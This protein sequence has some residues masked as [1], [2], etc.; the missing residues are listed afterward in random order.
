M[1]SI[2]TSLLHFITAPNR[3]IDRYILWSFFTVLFTGLIALVAYSQLKKF[4]TTTRA[5]FI[6]RFKKHF[7]T[8]SARDILSLFQYG[9]LKFKLAKIDY[10]EDLPSG[11]FP[12]FE[13]DK[14]IREQLTLFVQAK[15]IYTAYEIDDDLLGHIDDLGTFE[16]RRILDISIIYELFEYYITE[17]WENEEINKYVQWQRVG[18]ESYRDIY[19]NFEYIYNKCRQ[20][21]SSTNSAACARL[22]GSISEIWNNP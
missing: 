11:D 4:N 5:D 9:A 8:P 7:F 10:G 3:Y 22:F 20:R 12:Y 19:D 6:D 13:I 16:K 18:N 17:A 21:G 14:N 15:E 1:I 2:I